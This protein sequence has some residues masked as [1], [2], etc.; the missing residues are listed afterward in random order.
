M[1]NLIHHKN[2]FDIEASWTFCASGHGKGPS[3][4]IGA[5]VK[6]SANRSILKSGTTL[7]SPEDFFNF[8][9]KT[10]DEAAKSKDT[11][12]PP[13]NAYYLHSTTIH[14]IT[15]TLLSDR[16]K[17][18]NGE[19]YSFFILRRKIFFLGRIQDIRQCH[20]YHPKDQFTIFCRKTSNSF[21]VD[22]FTL[23]TNTTDEQNKSL[24][25]IKTMKDI[26]IDHIVILKQG[27]KQ[28]LANVIDI[29][30]PEKEVIAQCY[31]PSLSLSSYIRCFKKVNKNANI[32]YKN[33]IASFIHPPVFGRRDQLLLT[34]EQFIDIKKFCT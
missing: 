23:R 9:K 1:I 33:I 27:D 14:D 28:H 6:S 26:S 2:D 21:I 18:L 32:P 19:K 3:D 5:T 20:Q 11:N 29:R 13:I 31:E 16:F 22:E 8:T 24:Q 10:N 17:Q 34:K 30:E 7:S 12:E 4:G 25:Q 15:K